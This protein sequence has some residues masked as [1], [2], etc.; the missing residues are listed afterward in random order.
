MKSRA[1]SQIKLLAK[2]KRNKYLRS[3]RILTPST[4]APLIFVDKSLDETTFFRLHSLF[5]L[6]G[7]SFLSSAISHLQI[8]AFL[9]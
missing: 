2:T 7:T 8:E 3:Q 5:Y 9:K 1:E 6:F 4:A